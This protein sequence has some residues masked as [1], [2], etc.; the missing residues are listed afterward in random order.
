[1]HSRKKLLYA[2]LVLVL[3]SAYAARP[4]AARAGGGETI[5]QDDHWTFSM[6]AGGSYGGHWVH[7]H[8]WYP[9]N[10][11]YN[12]V[13]IQYVVPGR[14]V[15]VSVSTTFTAEDPPPDYFVVGRSV[16]CIG[17]GGGPSWDN[18]PQPGGFCQ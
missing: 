17:S 18:H 10:D 13:E 12:Y 15:P 16:R 1:M 7:P 6:D 9:D 8:P 2:T 5:A 4:P 11:D 3:L 14:N